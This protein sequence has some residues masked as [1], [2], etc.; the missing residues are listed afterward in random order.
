ML[1]AAFFAWFAWHGC[2][3]AAATDNCGP[4]GGSPGGSHCGSLCGSQGQALGDHRTCRT[5]PPAWACRTRPTRLSLSTS[6]VSLAS[7][8]RLA[9]LH[10]S[11]PGTA[12]APTPPPA[13]MSTSH[14]PGAP[15]SCRRPDARAAAP[16]LA[17]T[18]RSFMF[19]SSFRTSVES[20]PSEPPA[21]QRRPSRPWPAARCPQVTS[22][23]HCG[24]AS[25]ASPVPPAVSPPPP[26]ATM[27]PIGLL[28]RAEE[29]SRHSH[30]R[31]GFAHQQ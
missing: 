20:P 29:T 9:L 27:R 19:G 31:D 2:F 14:D 11:P 4:P 30:T 28:S 21:S 23:R 24:S 1:W 3:G 25:A 18:P 13:S 10:V 7:L 17:A 15:K 22:R 26:L 8:T 5:A 16:R 6:L 12:A